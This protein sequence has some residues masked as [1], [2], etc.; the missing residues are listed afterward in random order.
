ML[1]ISK[2]NILNFL[3]HKGHT[4]IQREAWG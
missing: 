2:E 3:S 4:A 1:N